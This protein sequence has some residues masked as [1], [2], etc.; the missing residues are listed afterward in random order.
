M[1]IVIT[2]EVGG[3]TQTVADPSGGSCG[4]AG[5][6]DRLVPFPDELPMLSRLDP[7]GHVTFPSAEIRAI[8]DEVRR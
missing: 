7:Y 2:L 6:F 8:C 1:R 3:R 4:A 5:D